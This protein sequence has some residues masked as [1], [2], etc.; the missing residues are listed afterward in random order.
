M[1]GG[2]GGEQRRA[3]GEVGRRRSTFRAKH[4]PRH[5]PS[6]NNGSGRPTSSPATP[7]PDRNAAHVLAV[8]LTRAAPVTSSASTLDGLDP[9]CPSTRPHSPL[10]SPWLRK[11]AGSR[12]PPTRQPQ[13]SATSR[14]ASSRPSATAS[15]ALDGARAQGEPVPA[16][17]RARPAHTPM[18]ASRTRLA[19]GAT[20]CASTATLSKTP[21]ARPV[22]ALPPP[23]IRWPWPRTS[24]P[25][26]R[27]RQW[28]MA[29]RPLPKARLAI[30]WGC[31]GSECLAGFRALGIGMRWT[32][33]YLLFVHF[34]HGNE[35]YMVRQVTLP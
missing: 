10:R 8:H 16:P 29:T 17:L 3:V 21:P 1:D 24:R 4:L 31:N 27:R 18:A 9:L 19:A 23:E 11:T 34:V 30:L 32:V 15:R 22:S 35:K 26:R 20:P 5:T 7:R 12:A 2:G 6:R 28:F 14:A 13:A 33:S 25:H